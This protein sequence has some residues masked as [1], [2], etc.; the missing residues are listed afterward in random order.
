M[1][2]IGI[3]GRLIDTGCAETDRCRRLAEERVR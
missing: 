2:L 1:G 3:G